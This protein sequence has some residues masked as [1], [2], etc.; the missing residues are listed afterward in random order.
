[1]HDDHRHLRFLCWKYFHFGHSLSGVRAREMQYDIVPQAWCTIPPLLSQPIPQL[2]LCH[3]H[4]N[5]T[6]TPLP[7]PCLIYTNAFV[8]CHADSSLTPAVSIECRF[9][10]NGVWAGLC[11]S[12]TCSI[13]TCFANWVFFSG[14]LFFVCVTR[15]QKWRH[16]QVR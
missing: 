6:V 3:I 8:L 10:K 4:H 16:L 1:M 9:R 13:R 11:I 5:I 7:S 2:S 12:L 15:K 14:K